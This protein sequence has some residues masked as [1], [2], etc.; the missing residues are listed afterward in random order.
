[1]NYRYAALSIAALSLLPVA[2][3][4]AQSVYVAPGG[5]YVANGPVYVTPAPG[6]VAP[7]LL[8]PT[9]TYNGNGGNG[10]GPPVVVAPT[11]GYNGNGGNGYGPPVVVAP[12]N[13]YNGNGYNGNGYNGYRAAVVV[14][15][16]YREPPVYASEF[17]PRP[18]A[19]IPYGGG[20]CVV[21]LGYGRWDYC[22]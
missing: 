6:V 10:Y 9:N 7:G 8:A 21:R 11:N 19:A 17:A 14:R 18:P 15:D 22:D 5:V 2:D 4:H 16:R 20:R 1:M 13:T 3:A 12:T